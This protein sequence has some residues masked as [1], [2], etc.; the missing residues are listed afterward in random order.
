MKQLSILIPSIN[1]SLHVPNEEFE[2]LGD[3]T[4]EDKLSLATSS[5]I[6]ENMINYG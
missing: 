3:S 4:D 5:D 1:F 6:A 2:P